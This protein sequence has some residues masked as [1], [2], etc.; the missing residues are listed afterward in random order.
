MEC[1]GCSDHSLQLNLDHTR[2][3]VD[4]YPLSSA[5]AS[6]AHQQEEFHSQTLTLK[7]QQP[8]DCS[9]SDSSIGRQRC[10]R[11]K[12]PVD[13]SAIGSLSFIVKPRS[14]DAHLC[15]GRCPFMYKPTNEHSQLQ[16][17]LHSRSR[18][19]PRG[20]FSFQPTRLSSVQLES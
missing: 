8:N 4:S 10:C 19:N 14:F 3:D 17:L 6:I 15:S 7:N 11:Q 16:S 20:N 2:L 12:M 5:V 18:L 13:L 9:T 1:I